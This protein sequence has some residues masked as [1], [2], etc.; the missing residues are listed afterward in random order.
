[1]TV[2]SYYNNKAYKQVQDSTVSFVV[3]G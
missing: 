1:M 2:P 3:Y